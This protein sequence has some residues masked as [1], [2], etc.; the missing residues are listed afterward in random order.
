MLPA[1]LPAALV[2]PMLR[3]LEQRSYDPFRFRPIMGPRRQWLLWRAAREP[4]R[5]FQP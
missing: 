1:L 2:G 5:I 3:R 4:K